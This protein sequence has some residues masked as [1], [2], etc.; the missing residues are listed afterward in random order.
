L[1]GPMNCMI[2]VFFWFFCTRI[3]THLWDWDL[4]LYYN[5]IYLWWA[6]DKLVII[7]C[8]W[9]YLMLFA[10]PDICMHVYHSLANL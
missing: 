9:C 7:W 1:F 8:Y 4:T 6:C 2:D 3:S 5:S 10:T